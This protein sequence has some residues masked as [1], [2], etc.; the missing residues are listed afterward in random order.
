METS[1]TI[2]LEKEKVAALL[3]DED[4]TFSLSGWS[5]LLSWVA[6]PSPFELPEVLPTSLVFSLNTFLRR[7][8]FFCFSTGD[9]S[10]TVPMFY[11]VLTR[12]TISEE[13]SD[14]MVL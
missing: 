11:D 6:S 13:F 5:P 7:P 3:E 14:V 2:F 8:V 12:A 10:M 4:L 1:K 9:P